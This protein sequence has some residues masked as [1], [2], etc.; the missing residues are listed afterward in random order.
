MTVSALRQEDNV[1][2]TSFLHFSY[3]LSLPDESSL[4]RSLQF[5]C[6]TAAL[7]SFLLSWPI[8]EWQLKWE[9]MKAIASQCPWIITG[10]GG[11]TTFWHVCNVILL[12]AAMEFDCSLMMC[13]HC[14]IALLNRW[15]QTVQGEHSVGLSTCMYLITVSLM[16][17]H[18][19]QRHLL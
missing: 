12:S 8:K 7:E 6:A 10:C 19:A 1:Y 2:I 17:L 13:S 4:T 11:H 14:V 18:L 3:A 9:S 15:H 16:V 5:I